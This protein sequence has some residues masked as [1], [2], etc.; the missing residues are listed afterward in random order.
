MLQ[1]LAVPGSGQRFPLAHIL[2]LRGFPSLELYTL[3]LPIPNMH[4]EL[5]VVLKYT[6]SSFM[7]LFAHTFRGLLS[8]NSLHGDTLPGTRD[9]VLLRLV[10]CF[11][12]RCCS[13]CCP[14][15][16]GWFQ[17]KDNFLGPFPSSI[18]VVVFVVL[19]SRPRPR[20]KNQPGPVVLCCTHHTLQQQPR[21]TAMADFIE[22]H[23]RRPSQHQQQLSAPAVRGV[24]LFPVR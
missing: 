4:C 19:R 18:V 12:F 21:H 16:S 2:F 8:C 3:L 13:C 10:M 7:T 11:R 1:I 17:N 20:S 24:F 15:C 9:L 5:G 14:C 6:H 23:R 22:V